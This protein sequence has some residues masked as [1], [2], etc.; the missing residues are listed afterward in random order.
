MTRLHNINVNASCHL[1]QLPEIATNIPFSGN[2]ILLALHKEPKLRV[3]EQEI[4]Q[5]E[6]AAKVA[7]NMRLPDVGVGVEGRQYSGDGEFRSGMFKLR[8][9]LPLANGGK[10]RKDYEPDK[11]RNKSA[12]E[13]REDQ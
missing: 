13:E 12:E 3:L 10:Y 6:A 4:K 7:R 8:F 2:L 5:A 9:S 1:L 11:E